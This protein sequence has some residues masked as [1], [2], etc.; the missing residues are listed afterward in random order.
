MRKNR[1]IQTQP[2]IGQAWTGRHVVLL[3]C[4]TDNQFINL[5][6]SF[7]APIEPPRQNCAETLSQLLS[8]G[9]HIVAIT[10]LSP[11]QIQ[12]LLVL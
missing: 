11:V 5:Y 8:I 6:K 9:Y 4:T 10:P 3:Q 12:Y 1:E 2:I 7:H